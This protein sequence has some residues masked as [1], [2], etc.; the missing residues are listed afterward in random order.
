MNET[1]LKGLTWMGWT[2]IL[3]VPG[4]FLFQPDYVSTHADN[5]SGLAAVIAWFVSLSAS[6]YGIP[7][8]A[9]VLA[10]KLS[11]PAGPKT[12]QG[13]TRFAVITAMLSLFIGGGAYLNEHWI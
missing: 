6:V 11:F 4:L 5:F 9:L 8:I 13:W 7:I 12:K 10:M 1:L 2:P 3:L